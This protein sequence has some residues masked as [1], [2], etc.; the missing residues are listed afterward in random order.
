MQVLLQQRRRTERAYTN[1][2]DKCTVF[3]TFPRAI[4][5]VKHTIQPGVFEIQPGSYDNPSRLVVGPSSWWRE[6]DEEMPLLEIPNTSIQVADSIVR[7]YCVGLLAYNSETASPGLFFLPGD[8]S[9]VELKT[10]HKEVF[11]RVVKKQK[12]WYSDLV[13]MADVLWARTN[14]NPIAISEDMRLG[15]SELGLKDKPWLNDF[16]IIAMINCAACGALRNPAY[17]I[18]GACKTVVDKALYDKL[19]LAGEK[20]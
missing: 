10:K 4:R 3:S 2:L 13:R 11:D 14:Q 5:E 1:P 15:A 7:D 18:C 6:I 16:S 9:V 12:Q 19:N 8:I 17:P 20:K